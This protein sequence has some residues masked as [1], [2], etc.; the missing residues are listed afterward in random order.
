MTRM[1]AIQIERCGQCPLVTNSHRE[2][3]DAFTSA[4]LHNTWWCTKAPD[5]YRN[6]VEQSG[7]PPEWCPLPSNAAVKPRSEAESA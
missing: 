4:P 6:I 7:E 3:D 2:H 5:R 1:Y